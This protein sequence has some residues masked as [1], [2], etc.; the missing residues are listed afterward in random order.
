M[1]L[2]QLKSAFIWVVMLL[3]GVFLS[4]ITI[5]HAGT[6][7]DNQ[8]SSEQL[9][10]TLVLNQ[11]HDQHVTAH[12]LKKSNGNQTFQSKLKIPGV[13]ITEQVHQQTNGRNI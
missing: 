8:S 9:E 13:S 12:S 2:S 4:V 3:S 1:I 5:A 7:E 11:G 10:N 6:N